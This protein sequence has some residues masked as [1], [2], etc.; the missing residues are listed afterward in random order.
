MNMAAKGSSRL[1]RALAALVLCL[2]TAS[3]APPQKP[4]AKS[5]DAPRSLPAI[6]SR[7]EF[8]SLA[9]VY[10][11]NTP[12]A[13]PHV[14]FAIDRQNSN[15]IYYINTQRYKFHK[16]FV[17][18]TYLSLERGQVFFE[19]NYLKA[20][21]RFILGTIAYQT[22]VRRWTFEFWEG[23][24]IP[25]EQIKLASDIINK[26]F[27]TPVAFKPNSS[28]QEE[29]SANL[30]LQRVLQTE[31]SKEQDYQ[32]LNVAKTLGRIHVIPRLDEHVEIG[33]NEILVLD[34][35]PV[36]LPPVAGIITA[37]PST[38]LSHINL[39]AKGWGVPNVYIRN[40]QELFKQYNG[41]WVEFDARRDTYSIKRADNNAL[42]EYQ[43]RLKERLDVMK[44]R[45]D[46]SATRL[47]GLNEQ[48]ASSSI[49]YGAKSA[50]LGELTHARLPGVIIPP[51]FTIPFFYYDQFL[52]ENKLDDAI[53]QM[54]NDQKFV[55]DPAYRREY[56]TKMRERIQQGT[57]NAQLRAEVLR[58]LHAEFPGKGVFARSST[59][60]EDLPNFSG[61]GLYSTAPNVRGDDQLVDAIRF[62]WASVWNFE[63]YEARERAGVEHTKIFMAVLIQEGIN[64]E[65][66][67]VMITT[68][69]FNREVTIE[70]QG[71]I[72]ISAK[73]GLGM[74]V[75]EGQ[76][77]AE[78]VVF[79][80]RANA[81]Q[82]LTRSEEDSLLT[83]DAH[84]GVREIPISGER[85]V[86]TDDVVRR[87]ANAAANIKRL[88]H[89]KDQDIE[90]A[91]M[92][93]QIYIVQSR[94]FIPGG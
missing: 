72:Y 21:R 48:R 9:V 16:D 79:R 29:A 45:Y 8:D 18:G 66:S 23:D 14:L 46:L 31:I 75:V 19:N 56:L 74:K 30:G 34:E 17:N 53:Y 47:A 64:S 76:K 86:L 33:S 55:H 83:F 6:H 87:L 5:T 26:S 22:P 61:A 67:G 93:G 36:Q 65:S 68:D 82:V 10:D 81:V 59:N 92:K 84:G 37:R 60:S 71:S 88:F 39:L 62:V 58:R 69:P 13:L 63:A 15:R 3:V 35:V 49:A 20:N 7:A 94:P 27:F 44:P 89:G 52:K 2:I 91:Y 42:D 77:V 38:P 57:I 41:W 4:S 32:A 70:N 40:A 51:G 73:R 54:L 50:N 12:Y 90:W 25:A 1:S 43:K 24:L 11:A 80:P 85:V 28:R 78:Q